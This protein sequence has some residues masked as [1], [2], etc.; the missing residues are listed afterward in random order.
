MNLVAETICHEHNLH[1]KV[2]WHGD[3]S[4]RIHALGPGH[5][6]S[7]FCVDVMQEESQMQVSNHSPALA[8]SDCLVF[9][10]DTG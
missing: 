9:L 6:H 8:H 2:K 1:V 10:H 3:L 5:A 7:G 4:K